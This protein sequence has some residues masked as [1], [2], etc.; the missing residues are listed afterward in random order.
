MKEIVPTHCGCNRSLHVA[1]LF[2]CEEESRN[3]IHVQRS[4]GLRGAEESYRSF[5]VRKRST[6]P[7]MEMSRA[8]ADSIDCQNCIKALLCRFLLPSNNSSRIIL[9]VQ[10][11]ILVQIVSLSPPLCPL[12][13]CFCASLGCIKETEPGRRSTEPG[14]FL[15]NESMY[16]WIQGGH[17][18]SLVAKGQR[19]RHL[20]AP[21]SLCRYL[22]NALREFLL[23][24]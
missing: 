4:A 22:K 2:T 1:L 20:M 11:L 6:E 17:G 9:I 19:Y 12:N 24:N 13:T 10:R 14:G 3:R 8:E 18:S 16:T 7:R 23:T 15:K 21:R 5:Q